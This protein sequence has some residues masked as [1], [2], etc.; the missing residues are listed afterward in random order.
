M[1][2]CVISRT[3]AALNVSTSDGMVIF[4]QGVMVLQGIRLALKKKVSRHNSPLRTTNPQRGEESFVK[5]FIFPRYNSNH[6]D[7]S[8]VFLNIKLP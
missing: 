6:V 8:F 7:D 5:T 1:V 4:V 3:T 2:P